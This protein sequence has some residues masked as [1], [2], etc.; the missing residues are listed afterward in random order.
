MMLLENARV[1]FDDVVKSFPEMESRI[2]I[3]ANIIENVILRALL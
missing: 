1:I 2:G 3:K